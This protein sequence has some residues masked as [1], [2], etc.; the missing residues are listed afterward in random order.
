MADT[1]PSQAPTR[2]W[3][4]ILPPLFVLI[5]AGV[6][7]A[8]QG[9]P[10]GK[11]LQTATTELTAAKAAAV[12]PAEVAQI[13][14]SLEQAKVKLTSAK[15]K[16]KERQQEARVFVGAEPSPIDR[17]KI[18]NVMHDCFEASNLTVTS[19]QQGGQAGGEAQLPLTAS[20]RKAAGKLA[21]TIDKTARATTPAA[22]IDPANMTP[23]V[24]QA[25]QN[26]GAQTGQAREVRLPALRELVVHGSYLNMLEALHDICDECGQTTIVSVNLERPQ[27]VRGG[28]QNTTRTWTLLVNVQPDPAA[29][30]IPDPEKFVVDQPRTH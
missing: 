14:A 4:L 28:S 23:E 17:L 16:M 27:S 22:P 21:T 9:V 6:V 1:N 15:A 3:V 24:L 7:V 12:S 8:Y 26:P 13:N 19:E 20:L 18:L 25:A 30:L 10:H 5:V 2:S 11:E 29:S